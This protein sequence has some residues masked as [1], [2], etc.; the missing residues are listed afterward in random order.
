M[1]LDWLGG[2]EDPTPAA[3]AC[4]DHL[5]QRIPLNPAT[6]GW[7]ATA[8]VLGD[9][10]RSGPSRDV[11]VTS[12]TAVAGLRLEATGGPFAH[13]H[14]PLATGTTLALTMA[15]AGRAAFCFDLEDAGAATLRQRADAA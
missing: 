10:D 4:L 9:R 15:M 2:V 8:A 7:N 14:R 3:H 6:A 11:T 12:R 5:A 1:V 13:A